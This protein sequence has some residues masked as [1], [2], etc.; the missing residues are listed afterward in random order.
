MRTVVIAL[1][2]LAGCSSHVLEP[3]HEV[4]GLRRLPKPP[5]EMS[6][7][8]LCNFCEQRRPKLLPPECVKDDQQALG[9]QAP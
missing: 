6:E 5:G 2:L 9:A 8:E 1:L 4:C 3:G 7:E